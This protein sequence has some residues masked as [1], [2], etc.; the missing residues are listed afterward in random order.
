MQAVEFYLN[1]SKKLNLCL[2]SLYFG[3]IFYVIFWP[4]LFFWKCLII[5][6]LIFDWQRNL[7]KKTRKKSVF[8]IWQDSDHRFGFETLNGNF[9]IGHLMGDS[10]KSS[11]FII[12]RIKTIT[13]IKTILIPRDSLSEV[14]YRILSSRLLHLNS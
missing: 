7:S 4:I 6:F 9:G 2:S 3:T 12:L 13:R 1:P 5:T 8:R 14:E 11:F 10:F